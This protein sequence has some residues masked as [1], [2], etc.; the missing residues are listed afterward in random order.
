MTFGTKIVAALA[1]SAVAGSTA[2]WLALGSEGASSSASMGNAEPAASAPAQDDSDT[3]TVCVA[4]DRIL[5][6]PMPEGECAPGQAEIS[7]EPEEECKLCPPFD[8]SPKEETS[9]NAALNDLDKRLRALENAPYF[10][11]VNESGRPV[12]R[13]GPDVVNVFNKS[14]MAMATFG[15]SQYGGYFAAGSG[16]ASIEASMGAMGTTAGIQV[17]EDGMTRL[18]VSAREGGGSSFRVPAAAGTIAGIGA[19]VDGPGAL[20]VGTL[21]GEVRASLTV[22][23]GRGMIRVLKDAKGGGVT[24]IEQGIGGGMFEID[25]VAGE[26]AIRMGHLNHR[27][28]I[29]MAGPRYKMALVPKSGLPG[30]YFLGCGGQSP[31]ACMPPE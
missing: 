17:V 9:D 25:N 7:L 5:H 14:G 23:N 18:T 15:S 10:E 31:P 29:V 24:L 4:A 13:V 19:S 20:L 8:D 3:V 26:A 22:P 30:S 6:A 27:Y 1:T 28:G 12:F 11:V 16:A 2:V 21:S